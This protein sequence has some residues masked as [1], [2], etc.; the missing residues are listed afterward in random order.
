MVFIEPQ[1]D[2]PCLIAYLT[3]ALTDGE[4]ANLKAEFELGACSQFNPLLELKIVPAPNDYIGKSH[5]YLRAKENEAG[6]DGAFV[7]IDEDY[8][9]RHAIWF[10]DAFADT[11]M[12]ENK[13]AESTEVVIKL[14][15][16]M[17][18]LA[19]SYINWEGNTIVLEDLDH[20]GVER[21][22]KNDFWQPEVNDCGGLDMKEQ[23]WDQVV[24]VTAEP[25]EFTETRD[26][27]LLENFSPQPKVLGKLKDKV[28][29]AAG[30]IASWTFINEAEPID[31]PDGSQK[32][33]PVGSVLL[34][35]AYNPEAP[36][37]KYKWPKGSL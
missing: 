31:M 27:T 33:F 22:L 13:E 10:V 3:I 12:V 25:G 21:P 9:K 1:R 26:K 28:A 8:I 15:I 14:L 34:Q 35:Q 23:Q 16:R 7:V 4:L 30:L 29:K 6:R 18:C 5:Q 36:W 2:I 37:P 32:T 24:D 17:D 11:D 19:L 20:A